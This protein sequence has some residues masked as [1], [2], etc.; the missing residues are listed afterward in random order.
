[1][2][3]ANLLHE[4]RKTGSVSRYALFGASR[5]LVQGY[6]HEAIVGSRRFDIL[7]VA[8]W[9]SCTIARGLS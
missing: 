7:P 9:A 4:W 2:A 1:M 6:V 3:A 8:C 5:I